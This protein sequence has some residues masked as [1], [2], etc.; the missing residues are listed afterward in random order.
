MKRGSCP[1]CQSP[2]VVT[3]LSL[4]FT[5]NYQLRLLQLLWASLPLNTRRLPTHAM[6]IWASS[7]FPYTCHVQAELCPHQIQMLKFQTAKTSE[8]DCIGRQNL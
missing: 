6:L 8:R 5:R 7:W 2:S 1:F 4:T 3:G